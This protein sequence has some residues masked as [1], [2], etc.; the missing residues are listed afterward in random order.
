MGKA[1]VTGLLKKWRG[2]DERALGEL[3]PIVYD[4]LHK[5]AAGHMR[6]ENAGHTLQATALVNEAFVKLVDASVEWDSR[7]HFLAVAANM[8]RRILIDH[9]K[10]KGRAKRGGDA[11]QVTYLE[12]RVFSGAE[13]EPDLL[14]LDMALLRFAVLDERKAK[15]VELSFFGGLTYDEIGEVLQISAATVDR[16]LRLG[17]AWLQKELQ[18]TPPDNSD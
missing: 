5:M 15:V 18:N 13:R 9:A 4:A 11:Q 7:A 16:E 17:K 2:G 10:A 6:K 1:A 3:T 12:S 14:D 8:M